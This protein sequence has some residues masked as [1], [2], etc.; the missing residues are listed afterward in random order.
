MHPVATI[1]RWVAT[2]ASNVSHFIALDFIVLQQQPLVLIL[3]SSL[4]PPI[5]EPA[6]GSKRLQAERRTNLLAICLLGV[7]LLTW[8]SLVVAVTPFILFAPSQNL[9][10]SYPSGFTC[11]GRCWLA[12][13]CMYLVP[14]VCFRFFC[15]DIS[16][17][18]AS[19]NLPVCF[20]K[21]QV[22]ALLNEKQICPLEMTLRKDQAIRNEVA[23]AMVA[24]TAG[25]PR[26]RLQAARWG[27]V[28]FCIWC[29]YK[30]N[31]QLQKRLESFSAKYYFRICCCYN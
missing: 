4:T 11:Y 6:K 28:R 15:R 17:Q 1:L 20:C 25:E 5:R 8:V 10:T 22:A 13:T 2:T 21:V 23:W 30:Q 14:I 29:Y 26:E 3:A 19:V 18:F 16:W 7:H 31:Q 24:S 27:T 12:W 9:S